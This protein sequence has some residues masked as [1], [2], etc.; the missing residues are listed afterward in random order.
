[1]VIDTTL[2]PTCSATC[3]NV[4]DR[5]RASLTWAG[6]GGGSAGATAAGVVVV[7]AA[8]EAG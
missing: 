8:A 5:V 2:G 4:R 3:E 6:E 1:M 7:G